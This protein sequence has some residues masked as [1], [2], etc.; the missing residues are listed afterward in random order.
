MLV[1]QFQTAFQPLYGRL[2]D[3]FGR[4]PM[5]LFAL[6]SFLIGSTL[7]GASTNMTMLIICRAFSGIVSGGNE[8]LAW[9]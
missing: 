5:L 7:C 8:K 2:S 9:R 6:T 4:K 1:C 3:I